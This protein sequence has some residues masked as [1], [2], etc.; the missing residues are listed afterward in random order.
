M[1]TA[2]IVFRKANMPTIEPVSLPSPTPDEMR[3]R[4]AYSGVSI[5]TEQSIFSGVRTHNGTFPV[6]TGYMASGTVEETGAAVKGFSEGARVICMGARFAADAGVN[7][8]WGGHSALQVVRPATC[9]H[10]PDGVD[11]KDAAMYVMPGVGL[12]AV[13]MAGIA[14]EDTVVIQGQGLI[15]QLCGQWCRNRGAKVITIEPDPARRE[16]SRKL[17]TEHVVDPSAEDVPE[18]VAALTAGNGATVV[19]EATASATFISS[20]TRL[21]CRSGKMVF[22]SWYPGEISIDFAHFHNNQITAYFP[23]GNGGREATRATLTALAN[24]S[25]CMAGNI[26]DVYPF[27]QACDGYRRI[28]EGDRSI[29]AMVVDWRNA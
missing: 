13:N 26:T 14:M 24:G 11:M 10:I 29:M 2:A 9:M 5:G 21:L 20:A 6:V 27:K 28:I 25:V 3:V 22:L 16:L 1:K 7:S 15:G 17:V 19:I 8:V 23:T 4:I 18:R 12:N